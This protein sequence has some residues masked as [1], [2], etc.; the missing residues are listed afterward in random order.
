MYRIIAVP[1]LALGLIITPPGLANP[2]HPVSCGIVC[3]RHHHKH[4]AAVCV[5]CYGHICRSYPC[6]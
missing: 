1:L 3:A 6:L 5:V 4:H 2:K